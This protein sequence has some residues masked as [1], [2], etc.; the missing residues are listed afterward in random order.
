MKTWFLR[1]GYP[2]NLV[3]SE[4]KKVKFLHIAK[5]ESQKRAL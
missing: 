2:K 3:E 5:N 1:R 4:I